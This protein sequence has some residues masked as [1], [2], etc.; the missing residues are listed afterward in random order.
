[1]SLLSK[2]VGDPNKKYLDSLQP[3][4]D[5]INSLESEFKGLSK[6]ELQEKT[7]EFKDKLKKGEIK[8]D[9]ILAEAFAMVREA[10]KRT[11]KQRHYDVQLL[12]GIILHQGRIAE[13]KTGEGKTLASTLPLY[14]N[15]LFGKGTHLVTVNDYLSKRDCVWMG[16]I[17]NYLGISVAAIEHEASYIYDENFSSDGGDDKDRSVKVADDYLRPVSR[18]EAYQAD[19]VYGTNNEFGFDYLRDNMKPSLSEICQ[20]D[21]YYC[22]IDEVD[23]V[24]VDEARTPLIISSP[25]IE[26]TDKYIK[27]AQVVSDLVENKHY[28]VDEKMHSVTFSEDGQNY[29]AEKLG[30]DPWAKADFNTIFHLEAALKVSTPYFF[31]KDKDYIV[32]DGEVIIVDGFTGR[33][34]PGRRYSEGIHQAIEA[35]EQLEGEKVSVQRESMTMATITFQNYFRM[36]NKLAGMT[37]TAATEA[38]EFAKIYNLEVNIIPTNEPMIR[39]DLNDKIYKSE[40][41]KFKA[42][43]EDVKNR[44][45]KGQPVLIGTISI[46]KNEILGELFKKQGIPY[47][48]LNAKQH[49]REAEIIAQAGRVG[50]VTV[51]TNMA[52]RGVDIILGGNPFNEQEYEKVKKLGGLHV[53]GT[54]RHESRRID[55]QLRG[56]S[57]RQGDSG[58][59][60]FYVSMDDDLMR[61]FGSDRMKSIMNTL[62]LPDDM[63]IE[64]KLISKS[65]ERAQVRV[66]GYNFDIRKHLVEYDDVINKQREL[67]YKKR[68]DILKLIN[69]ERVENYDNLTD[70]IFELINNEISEVVSFHTASEAGTVWNI[71][72]IIETMK[73]IFPLSDNEVDKIRDISSKKDASTSSARGKLK[74]AE[75]RTRIINYFSGLAKERYKELKNRLESIQELSSMPDVMKEIE[76]NIL[77]HSIDG[78]WVE[79]L[80]NID[81][82]RTGIGLRGY[83]QSDPLVEYKRESYDLFVALLNNI[84]N[85]VVY[86]IFKVGP[87][88]GAVTDFKERHIAMSSPVD[89]ANKQ[90]NVSGDLV[91]QKSIEQASKSESHNKVVLKNEEIRKFGHKVGRNDPCPCGATKSDGTPIK[92]KNCCGR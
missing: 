19:I 35:R 29:I 43:I 7:S 49:E 4:V 85:Q 59:S 65:I 23:S 79:H 80:D 53:L 33:L 16:Q 15:A 13:M 45:E 12:A 31:N 26:S 11:L 54:E 30:N 34:M 51:A 75:T 60:Q 56:R 48:L 40:E 73:T 5:K 32:K 84:Q 41:G 66:E 70:Y 42:L 22:I 78:L 72:E 69:N 38:E 20:R 50:A 27:F 1:M 77:L 9:D 89:D 47:N 36:Y 83:A 63:P 52:G 82:L 44:H 58:S 25:D 86:S 62:K 37:G 55:N 46:E 74:E 90:F 21:F 64:N 92:Y 8:L 10:A 14:L 68:N 24:L 39:V 57:G 17:Y 76:K 88:A 3:I 2:L 91:Q 28:N 81:H 6:E 87:V 61:I 71:K 67:I 18:K